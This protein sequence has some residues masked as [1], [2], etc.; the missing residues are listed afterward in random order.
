MPPERKKA[1][2]QV[3]GLGQEQQQ[4]FLLIRLPLQVLGLV[5]ALPQESR[6]V[7]PQA[8]GLVRVLQPESQRTRLLLLVRDP[9]RV[10]LPVSRQ[11]MLR[12]PDLV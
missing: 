4:A 2:L 1:R 11:G 5:L 9:G 8:P 6:L 3:L 12:V 7:Q 10:P